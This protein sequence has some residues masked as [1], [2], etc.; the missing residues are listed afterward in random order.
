VQ[1]TG[2]YLIIAAALDK[3]AL[4]TEQADVGLAEWLLE[5]VD[6]EDFL[7]RVASTPLH[8][9]WRWTWVCAEST[10]ATL[11]RTGA[12]ATYGWLVAAEGM[13]RDLEAH[14]IGSRPKSFFGSSKKTRARRFGKR[15]AWSEESVGA[16]QLLL[17]DQSREIS[18]EPVQRAATNRHG[19]LH[20]NVAGI[21]P[22]HHAVKAFTV[23]DA[24][25]EMAQE[26]ANELDGRKL[27]Q[28]PW[29]AK[30]GD[31]GKE[32]VRYGPL[33]GMTLVGESGT[34]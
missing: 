28:P 11:E 21:I 15:L 3:G 22:I 6:F 2:H 32:P 33:P 27:E 25:V 20:G 13:W 17:G 10:E 30:S 23:V 31:I 8:G 14:R 1:Q 19:F 18:D 26:Y 12:L 7:N 5:Y 16:A 9:V 34:A 4:T 29:L 24:L